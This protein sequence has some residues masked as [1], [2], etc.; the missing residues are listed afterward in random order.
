MLEEIDKQ[1]SAPGLSNLPL[2]PAGQVMDLARLGCYHPTRLSFMRTLMRRVM[3]EQWKIVP[4]IFDLD[5]AGF[6]TVVYEIKAPG[7]T[8]SF[9]LFSDDIDPLQRNDRVIAT[10]WDLTMAMC[11]GRVDATYL[12][13]LR[14]NVRQ[15][16]AGR[17]DSRVFI[18]SRA[19][20]S[21]RN[22]ESIVSG[23]A[24]GNQP[25]LGQ[26]AQVGY[27]YR[28]TAVYGSGKMGM[29]DWAK[30]SKKYPDFARPFA[31]EMFSCFMLRHFS[32]VQVDHIAKA[33]A[34]AT[35]VVMDDNI[36]R[37]F[38]IGNST[39]MGMAPYLV[40]H[41]LLVSQWIEVLETALARVVHY[42]V[43]T[44]DHLRRLREMAGKVIQHIGQVTA[45]SEL[46][47]ASNLLLVEDMQSL[48]AW[49]DLRGES[50]NSWAQ[51]QS[52]AESHW[53]TE[54]GEVI[55]SLLIEMYPA[56]VDDLEEQ[57]SVEEVQD[58]QPEMSLADLESLIERHYRWAL[59]IDFE[60]EE[61]QHLFWY[62]SE[63]KLE[64]R[65]GQ[66]N[67]DP[68]KDREMALAIGQAVQ[69]CY[70][71]VKAQ[72]KQ[73]ADRNVARLLLAQPELKGV[74]RRIQT[75]SQRR[76]GEI[77]ENLLDKNL[78]PVHLLRCKLTFFGVSKFNPLSQRWVRNTM[79]QGAPIVGDIGKPF[80]DDWYFPITPN[81]QE[82]KFDEHVADGSNRS[83]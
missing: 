33:R 73:H 72:R 1:E 53:R 47:T 9:V 11:E 67:I 29:A 62:R 13:Q 4:V 37:Y 50:L 18:L 79:F 76:Y 48:V 45:E 10:R 2:R 54:A 23:L 58:I 32:L 16:E 25:D 75:M 17:F 7:G 66:R 8:Y 52:H 38:G 30:V 42:G 35:A 74:V 5:A 40:M 15:Q 51:L 63:D 41:P 44:A 78:I 60:R 69:A 64:P 6:G 81:S 70:R 21:L 55:K 65:I 36:R 56:L 82:G 57:M 77:Q 71:Q 80:A 27:L 19:N 46:Q 20:R 59:D 24:A 26:V 12:V 61:A 68:G 22:F 43:V 28:T 14:N 34:P 3:G 83:I 39:G 31:A 49:L